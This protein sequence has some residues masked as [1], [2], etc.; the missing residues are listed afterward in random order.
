MLYFI[1]RLSKIFAVQCLRLRTLFMSN[2]NDRSRLQCLWRHFSSYKRTCLWVTCERT[3]G[4]MMQERGVSCALKYA[5][6]HAM[7]HALHE[8]RHRLNAHL[9]LSQKHFLCRKYLYSSSHCCVS[10][11]GST[12]LVVRAQCFPYHHLTTSSSRKQPVSNAMPTTV[13]QTFSASH[14]AYGPPASVT[15]LQLLRK[16]TNIGVSTALTAETLWSTR[17]RLCA[18]SRLLTSAQARYRYLRLKLETLCY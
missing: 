5:S 4:G 1:F 11:T 10:E 3:G 13:W 14:K 18:L 9:R 12:H 7:L 17:R 16:Q 2:Y 8:K 15:W 6:A